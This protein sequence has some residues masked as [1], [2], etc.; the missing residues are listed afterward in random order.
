M[1]AL[2]QKHHAINLGQG[3]PD[4]DIDQKLI[5]YVTQ[6]MQEGHNQYAPMPGNLALR[7][8]LSRKIIT[9]YQVAIDPNIE[10]T[11][12]AGATQAIFT[13]IQALVHAGDE[14][15]V[16]E[17]AYDCYIPAILLCGALPVCYRMEA[18]DF[19]VDWKALSKL[20][21]RHTRMII[22]NTP[23]NPTGTILRDEDMRA[24]SNIVQNTDIIIL[25]DEV[26]EH[27]IFDGQLHH[28]IIQYPE[29]KKRGVAVFSFGKTFH[30]TGWKLGYIVAPEVISQEIRKVHQYNVFSVNSSM[31]Q[32]LAY[33]LT[34]KG[35]YE[36]LEKFYQD[37]RDFLNKL[38]T[39]MVW[40]PI[41]SQ[42]TYF[43]LYSYADISHEADIDYAQQ[44]VIKYGVTTIP[45][46]V[47]Y[48]NNWDQ[49]LLRICFAKKSQTLIDAAEKLLA[50]AR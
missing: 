13:I 49:K 16:M 10:I 12:T 5:S 18:P 6:A 45:L 9:R 31:Q 40:N 14:V 36:G 20:I 15:L 19:K 25:S 27:I 39:T 28:T 48:T 24:L 7:E 37:K 26:Y 50:M 17:P 47:F 34:D 43:Q 11:I 1:S 29:L 2:A 22:I 33:Y 46:S 3:F 21:N 35:V 8:S 38:L 30:T 23:H 44:L 42:G 41:L 4:F 32:G